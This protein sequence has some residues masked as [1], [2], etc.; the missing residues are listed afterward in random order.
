MPMVT[1]Y[2]FEV[3]RIDSDEIVKSRRWGTRDAITDIAHGRVLEETGIEVDESVA[4]SDIHGFTK[5][6]FDPGARSPGFQ[7]FVRR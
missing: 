3:Y 1:I 6:D 7:T 2:Q 5:R 4:T